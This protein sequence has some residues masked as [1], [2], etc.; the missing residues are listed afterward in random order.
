MLYAKNDYG[1]GY[2][3]QDV[4]FNSHPVNQ[5]NP[6]PIPPTPKKAP[7][8]PP[9][10]PEKPPEKR[11]RVQ[12]DGKSKK[13]KHRLLKFLLSLIVI[14]VLLAAGYLTLV[15]SR[16]N[17]ARDNP[18][19]QYVISEVGELKSDSQVQNIIIFG[20]DNH[21]AGENGRSDSMILISIDK[22]HHVIKQTSFLRD[23]YVTIPENGEE[24]LNA[25]F[26]IGGAKL[27]V[28]TIEYN[29][30][31]KIDSY[32]ILGFDDFISIVD[33]L[34][35]IDLELT[36]VE[37][38][39][40]N[41][42]SFRNKQVEMEHE[43]DV[44]D[45]TFYAK[46]DDDDEDDEVAKVHVN[47][48]QALWY[49][50]DRDSAGSD[51]DRTARQRIVINTILTQLKEA[52]PITLLKVIYDAAP[53]IT[54]NMNL[55]DAFGMSFGALSYLRYDKMEFRVPQSFNYSNTWVGDA[56]VLTIDNIEEEKK[57]LYRFIFEAE[58][59][60]TDNED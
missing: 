21:P 51:F 30:N 32:V 55:G 34:G 25:A 7:K 27:A 15:I 35:G 29:F 56:Q 18:D 24:K 1:D 2:N 44:D 46:N 36:K 52:N 6:N 57:A 20:A 10:P 3:F 13:K 5:K 42:Q 58:P 19:E 60:K 47:G 40:I 48:R 28:E 12:S 39:Y 8:Q 49:A 14:I 17:Y 41:N 23:L 9:K 54:T 37:I 53:M 4:F 33:S 50:R 16:V 45:Y 31:I 22:K 43:L 59:E 11:H 26:A 38:E